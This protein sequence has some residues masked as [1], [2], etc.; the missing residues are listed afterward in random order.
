M[1]AYKNALI[2]ILAIVLVLGGIAYWGTSPTN[3][4]QADKTSDS[5]I[6]SKTAGNSPSQATVQPIQSTPSPAQLPAKSAEKPQISVSEKKANFFKLIVP[7]VDTVYD[8]LNT[9]YQDTELAIQNNPDS[10]ALTQ[11]RKKYRAQNNQQLLIALKPSPR[12]IAIAQAAI[13]SAWATSRFF[14]E[15]NNVFGVWSF[16]KNEPRIA[17]GKQRGDKTIWL[18]KYPS[19]EASIRDYYLTL[20]RGGPFKDFRA[21][22]MQTDDPFELV[23]QLHNYS[24]KGDEYGKELA[25]IIR[26][27]NLTQYD[28]Q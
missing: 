3:S 21:R 27:N 13:E 6:A 17:A 26:F 23:K 5:K 24:E 18:K 15:A 14:R 28:K 11:L 25:S 16:N 9:Q 4:Q 10:E 1:F 12:S 22:K 7:A 20:A 8:Q 2:F 19:V